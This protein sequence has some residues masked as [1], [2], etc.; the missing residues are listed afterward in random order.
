MKKIITLLAVVSVCSMAMALSVSNETTWTALPDEA[1]TDLTLDKFDTSQGSLTGITLEVGTRTLNAEVQLDN[2]STEPQTGT[3]KVLNTIT[4]SSSVS[5]VDSSFQA[6]TGA[7][8]SVNETQAFELEATSG[9]PV[10]EFNI[11]T[12]DDYADWLPGQ[13]EK[14]VIQEIASAVFG[15]Y[16]ASA[17][18]EEFTLSFTPSMLTGAT[19]EGENG[20]FEGSSPNAQ[21]F[22]KVTYEYIPEPMTMALL[23]LGGLF[24]RRRSA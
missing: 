19:F 9:D 23:G 1:Q 2:D 24:V 13:I 20:H 11:T 4:F 5:T 12:G 18:D 6:I 15:Q 8:I 10:G 16:E 22:A 14:Y 3:G 21:G 7:D 17:G